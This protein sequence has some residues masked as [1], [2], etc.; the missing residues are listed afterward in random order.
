MPDSDN[1]AQIKAKL[2]ETLESPD[3]RGPLVY[4]LTEEPSL[5]GIDPNY[6]KKE[7]V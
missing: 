6:S 3:R 1:S 5:N 2:P 4:E 7:G